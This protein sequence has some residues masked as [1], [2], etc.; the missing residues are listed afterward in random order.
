MAGYRTLLHASIAATA[1]VALVFLSLILSCVPLRAAELSV[2]GPE[3]FQKALGT[4]VMTS[5]GKVRFSL[6]DLYAD[7][8]IPGKPDTIIAID[9]A[10]ID[11]SFFECNSKLSPN[12]AIQVNGVSV[13]LL[14]AVPVDSAKPQPITLSMLDTAKNAIEFF[15]ENSINNLKDWVPRGSLHGLKL[16]QVVTNTR[17][18]VPTERSHYLGAKLVGRSP[19]GRYVRISC[20]DFDFSH[21]RYCELTGQ[22]TADTRY[23]FAIPTEF[24][25]DWR[26]YCAVAEDY[27]SAH[28]EK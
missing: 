20:L 15:S 9:P 10:E 16:Y 2:R 14:G 7:Y 25:S 17:S 23:A 22:F 26:S 4:T 6:R 8:N 28:L 12:G 13:N 5:D 21:D 1:G 19:G 18:G 27:F 24:M 11:L 3:C